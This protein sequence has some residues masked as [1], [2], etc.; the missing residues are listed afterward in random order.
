LSAFTA[1]DGAEIAYHDEGEGR[2]LVFL[3]G[4][5]ANAEFFVE[6][7]A[8]TA[9]GF[10]VIRVDLRGHGRTASGAAEP[11]LDRLAADVGELAERLGL[12][13]AVAVGW[14]LG[15]SVVWRLLAGRWSP[16]FAGAAV[17][18]MTPCVL[19]HDGW[20][21]GLSQEHVDARRQAITDD[22]ATFA[23]AAGAAIFAQ[24]L[25]ARTA[26]MAQWA[27]DAFVRA[28]GRAVSALWA[29][30][31]EEDFREALGRIRQPMLVVHGAHSHL[32]GAD[33]AEHIVAALPNGRGLQF[34]RSGHSPHLEQPE[35]FNRALSDFA[36][37]LPPVHATEL[38]A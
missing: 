33:T 7:R 18:D 35:R 27:A 6:Q 21:L 4:L 37:S 26:A 3:H 5:M 25:D 16:R 19:N 8:L 24:P 14:S 29:S 22:F 30:L 10:R 2:P 34:D 36:A 32:Y 28:D 38:T 31:V 11:T 17:I 9:Q 20:T 1:S 15:A 13:G 12:E 23:A